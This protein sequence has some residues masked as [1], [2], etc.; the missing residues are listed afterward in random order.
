MHA[1]QQL[2]DITQGVTMS[3]R[4][5]AELCDKQ[6]KHVIRDIRDMFTE[7][8]IDEPRFGRIHINQENR[9]NVINTT[10]TH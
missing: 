9:R 1:L 3:S 7:L 5:I 8:K 2:E 10:M 4:E 6:H